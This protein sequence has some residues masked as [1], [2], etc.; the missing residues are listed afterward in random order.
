MPAS[1]DG[2]G[3]LGTRDRASALAAVAVVQAVLALALLSGFRVTVQ[4]SG[5]LVERLIQ[6]TLPKV[7]PPP[8]PVVR[9]EPRAA[10][11]REATAAAPRTAPAPRG[12]SPGSVPAHALPSVTPIVPIQPTAPPSGGGTGTGPALGSGQGGGPGGTGYGEGGEGGT[13]LEQI[14]GAIYPSDYPRRLR[15]AGI[16]GTVEF[17]FTV[18]VNGRVAGC[19]ITRSSGV[20]EL[21][22]LTCRLVQQ[23]FR[24]RP[25]TDRYGR[26]Y[27][28]VVEGEHEW[29]AY[30][31]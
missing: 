11:P 23:R 16:G 26:P 17:E 4:R 28:E 25:S 18:G 12:G 3:N 2:F 5:E 29:I 19:R 14:A 10:Q 6:I 27:P 21:D 8:P 22:L 9:V 15:E 31:R 30:R 20:V 13:D 24:Y 7:P 1:P